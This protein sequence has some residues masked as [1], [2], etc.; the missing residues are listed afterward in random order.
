EILGAVRPGVSE[1]EAFR[2]APWGGE[3]LSFHPVFA[4][5]P[6]VA[7]G[8]TSPSSRRLELGDAAIAAIGL[9]GGNCAR[10]GIVAASE[11]DLGSESDGYLERMAVPYWRAM[12]TWYEA[13]GVGVPGGEVFDTVTGILEGEAFASSLHPGHL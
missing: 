11:A 1:R 10:G 3:P 5:G 6:N 13:L 2:A 4:S 9:W 8:L 12:A 7:I